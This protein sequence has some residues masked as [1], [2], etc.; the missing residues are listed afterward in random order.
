MKEH[1][2][3][4]NRE[5]IADLLIR[6]YCDNVILCYSQSGIIGGTYWEKLDARIQKLQQNILVEGLTY[7]IDFMSF[8]NILKY[9]IL[10]T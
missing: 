4:N 9:D 7:G 5:I 3:M 10:D 8:D 1:N 2:E 6:L